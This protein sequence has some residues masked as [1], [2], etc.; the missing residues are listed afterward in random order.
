MIVSE[1]QACSS[2]GHPVKEKEGRWKHTNAMDGHVFTTV[3]CQECI[4]AGK[5]C[6][7]P[8]WDP[9][10][11]VIPAKGES[12]AKPVKPEE[13]FLI[14]KVCGIYARN[15]AALMRHFRDEHPLDP[16]R[17]LSLQR[18]GKSIEEMAVILERTPQ[19]VRYHLERLSSDSEPAGHQS[20]Q[21]EMQSSPDQVAVSGTADLESENR[22]LRARIRDLESQIQNEKTAGMGWTRIFS[23]SSSGDRTHEGIQAV[24]NAIKS[25]LPWTAEEIFLKVDSNKP[26]HLTRIFVEVRMK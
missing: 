20:V 19:T 12:T 9:N 17:L 21:L 10:V 13:S 22:D 1:I 15:R 5:E 7:D 26:L 8:R 24:K 16:E 23:L 18:E 6:S 3:H 2:C 14:C 11:T 4:A 25:A